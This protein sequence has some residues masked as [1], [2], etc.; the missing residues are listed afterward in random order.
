MS[1]F[2]STY[3]TPDGVRTLSSSTRNAPDASRIRSIP[4]MWMYTP[5]HDGRDGGMRLARGI[6]EFVERARERRVSLEEGALLGRGSR[7][8]HRVLYYTEPNTNRNRTFQRAPLSAHPAC[9]STSS[10]TTA[11]A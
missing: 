2:S 4:A 7:S 11:R 10:S 9:R 8:R 5:P 6:D 1:R 3:E